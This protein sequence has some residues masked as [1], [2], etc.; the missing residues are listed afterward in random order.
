MNSAI[1]VV[2]PTVSYLIAACLSWGKGNHPEALLMA[3]YVVANFGLIWR[4][5]L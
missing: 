5:A 3:G 2:I 4:L 1:F